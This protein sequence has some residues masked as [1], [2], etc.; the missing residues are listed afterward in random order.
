[1][2]F[3]MRSDDGDERIEESTKGR[4]CSEGCSLRLMVLHINL[5]S[6]GA[7]EESG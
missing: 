7:S 3:E 5:H 2:V 1:M 4:Q 6:K